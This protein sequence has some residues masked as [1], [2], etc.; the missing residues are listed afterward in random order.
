MKTINVL[1]VEELEIKFKDG[2]TYKASFNMLAVGYM[3][4]ALLSKNVEEIE[5]DEWDLEMIEHAKK[6]ND[7]QGI[8]TETL[9]SELGAKL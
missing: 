8:P 3:Q 4:Q 7:G 5:P 6:I 2:K 9:A 1:P